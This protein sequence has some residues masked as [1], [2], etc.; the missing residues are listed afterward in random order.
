MVQLPRI[1]AL[2]ERTAAAAPTLGEDISDKYSRTNQSY[3][4]KNVT[5][6]EE[7]K[8]KKRRRGRRN[9]REEEGAI[10][11]KRKYPCRHPEAVDGTAARLALKYINI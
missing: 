10:E 11:E 5:S 8:G 6:E 4:K 7:E 3:K 1:P 9:G 2:G